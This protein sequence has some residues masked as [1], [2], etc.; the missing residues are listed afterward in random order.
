M[1]VEAA[2]AL[3]PHKCIAVPRA[4][5]LNNSIVALD[6][7]PRDLSWRTWAARSP[8]WSHMSKEMGQMLPFV[9]SAQALENA[10]LR[11]ALER[12]DRAADRTALVWVPTF[13]FNFG[14]HYINSVIPLHELQRRGWL[15]RSWLL[16][17]ELYHLDVPSWYEALHVGLSDS[18]IR[19]V[20]QVAPRCGGDGAATAAA[21]AAA[22]GSAAASAAAAAARG[23]ANGAAVGG[24]GG[25]GGGGQGGNSGGGA[26]HRNEPCRLRAECF[27]RLVLC[28]LQ[29]NL[30]RNLTAHPFAPWRVGQRI[31]KLLSTDQGRLRGPRGPLSVVTT[32][33]IA[34]TATVAA[35]AARRSAAAAAA[36]AAAGSGSTT[37]RL[38]VIFIKREG[39]RRIVNLPRLLSACR[40]RLARCGVRCRGYTFGKRSVA[41]D[42][43]EVASAD[44][45]VGTHG[46]GLANAFFMHRGSAVVEIRPYGFWGPWPDRYLRTQL[47]QEAGGARGPP[48][49]YYEI[50]MGSPWLNVPVLNDSQPDR[51]LSVFGVWSSGVRAPW[52][53]VAHVLSA[54]LTARARND[55]IRSAAGRRQGGGGANSGG[56]GGFGGGGGGGGGGGR[57]G[58]AAHQPVPAGNRFL[59]MEHETR[60]WPE[61]CALEKGRLSARTCE[62]GAVRATSKGWPLGGSLK[63]G[64]EVPGGGSCGP[65]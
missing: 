58:A 7:A 34:A 40:S 62:N 26:H 63:R 37:P 54:I 5:L 8:V 60:D 59:A 38:E 28:D 61:E 2:E 14:E 35:A 49:R 17:P 51:P 4:C 20:A 11:G 27:S 55:S 30:E 33:E 64:H 43:A 44:V 47:R 57:G 25:G 42:A 3:A 24:G 46:A 45:L 21:A 9:T 6:D 32:A 39:G 36:A 23:G 10:G 50:A 29:G 1:V 52:H 19:T 13:A 41:E 18:P 31:A 48:L 22:A 56:G 15:Q 16:R 65:R 53:S 12:A